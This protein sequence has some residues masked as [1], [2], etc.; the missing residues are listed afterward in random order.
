MLCNFC[1]YSQLCSSNFKV[2]EALDLCCD[3][4][5]NGVIHILSI[6]ARGIFY[7]CCDIM[8]HP[9]WFEA[10]VRLPKVSVCS[11]KRNYEKKNVNY[12]L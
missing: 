1:N 8:S 7:N 6:Y 9:H 11:K 12:R 2:W 4:Y 3:A 5:T 10:Y